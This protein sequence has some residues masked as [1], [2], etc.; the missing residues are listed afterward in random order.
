MK[1][2]HPAGYE[3]FIDFAGTRLEVV[4]RETGEVRKVEVFVSVLPF[5]LYTYV[6][7]S[8]S[9]KRE[10]LIGC[11][12]NMMRFYKGVPK[13]VV[14]D[15]LKSAV[16]KTSKFEPQINRSLKDFARHY[17]CVINPTRPYSPQDKALVENA[18]QLSYQRIY[19]PIKKMVFFSV[20]ELNT[21]IK[22]LLE[23]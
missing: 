11:M 8:P 5:S 2:D 22:R 19:Y 23:H 3:V 1:L 4:D 12:N 13:A 10:D 18:V 17:N 7:A 21:E 20:E 14:S 9:Q 15:N 6:E 16:S